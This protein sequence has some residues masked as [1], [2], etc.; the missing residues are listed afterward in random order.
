MDV[1]WLVTVT[2]MTEYLAKP[3][4]TKECASQHG[5]TAHH[6]RR[7]E[8]MLCSQLLSRDTNAGAQVALLFRM[9]ETQP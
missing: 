2:D 4:R 3:L 5:S 8:A 7:Q 6:S 9:S 1:G